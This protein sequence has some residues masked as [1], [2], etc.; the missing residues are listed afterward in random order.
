MERAQDRAQAVDRARTI[1]LVIALVVI[2]AA[3]ALV[4]ASPTLLSSSDLRRWALDPHGLGMTNP[5]LALLVVLAL[6]AAALVCVGMVTLSAFRGETA[7]A[8]RLLTWTF[9]AG[10]AI[11]NYRHG[12]STPAHDDEF[13]FPAMSI[14]GPL[15][16]ELTLE[17]VRR[18]RNISTGTQLSARP[19]FGRRWVPGVA[20]RETLSAWQ[21]AIRHDL[22]RPADALDVV[23]QTRALRK[24]DRPAALTYA[25]D[26]LGDDAAPADIHAW[27]AIRGVDPSNTATTTTPD[28]AKGPAALT[29]AVA[30]TAGPAPAGPELDDA[31]HSGGEA[32][33][34][35]AST[36]KAPSAQPAADQPEQPE[37]VTA[38]AAAPAAPVDSPVRIARP[39]GP[40]PPRPTPAINVEAGAPRPAA[41]P[42][43]ITDA[44]WNWFTNNPDGS[45]TDAA[46]D[47]QMPRSTVE[48]WLARCADVATA[49]SPRQAPHPTVNHAAPAA[50][51]AVR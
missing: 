4:V 18:W 8:F 25:R 40:Q 43:H 35:D 31:Q 41:L 47:L 32:P 34:T 36:P 2:C 9:A 13:F 39:R 23:R 21:V 33:H 49:E 19:R 27:L 3:L 7:N 10:S 24:L 37:P 29:P 50:L 12:L 6:D 30:I 11:A 48:R 28:D 46:R 22:A 45:P 51:V 15:L 26:H 16:L 5:A 42:A 44:A 1:G 20:F 14:A 17:R 38:A